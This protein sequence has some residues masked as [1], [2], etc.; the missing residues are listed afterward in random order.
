PLLRALAAA[1]AWA[2]DRANAAELAQLLSR[3][4]YLGVPAELVEDAL[5]G[6]LALGAGQRL[7]DADFLF[8]H[9]HAA[10]VPHTGEALWLYTQMV[11]WGQLPASAANREIAARVFRPDLYALHLGEVAPASVP[12][13]FDNARF[14]PANVAAY[15]DREPI[16]TP[17]IATANWDG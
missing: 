10:N 14:D 7:D 16:R 8:F 5:L 15:L 6:R 17:F 4:E 1:A 11:R 2:D 12:Q 9:R 3:P 13:P